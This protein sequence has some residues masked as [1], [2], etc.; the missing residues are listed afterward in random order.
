[1]S[2]SASL[3][4]PRH[5]FLLPGATA[6]AV[7]TVGPTMLAFN[8][9]PSSTFFNQAAAVA[10]WGLAL[11]FWSWRGSTPMPPTLPSSGLVALLV[12]LAVI[13]LSAAGSTIFGTLPSSIALSS[14][15]LVASAMLAAWM[16][17]WLAATGR[18]AAMFRALCIGLLIA[19]VLSAI[20]AAIQVFAPNWTT[21]EWI[22]SSGFEGRASGNLRQPNHLSSLLLWGLIA[23]VWAIESQ[24]LTWQLASPVAVLLVFGIVASSS[25]TG[26]VGVA[27]LVGWGVFDRKLLR[28]TRFLLAAIPVLYA[29]GW[30]AMAAWA[31]STHGVFLGEVRMTADGDIS[32]SRFAIWS[33]TLTL[34]K[35]HPWDGVGFGE[36]NFAWSLTPFPHRPV[37]FFDHTHNLL[38]QLA[39][40]LGIPLTI[41]VIGL[42]L[43]ALTRAFL[44]GFMSDG[45][46]SASLRCAFMIVLMIGLH[47]LLEYPLW[48]AYFLIPTAIAFGL[49][50]AKPPEQ[51]SRATIATGSN[52]V[53]TDSV[54]TVAAGLMFAL[55]VFSVFDYLRVADIFLSGS[56]IPL[57][58]RIEAGRHSIFFA[59]QADYAAATTTQPPMAAWTSFST[60]TH[61]LLD[62][63]LMI[64]WAQA[65]AERGDLDRAQHI[66]DRL[67][68]FRN[69]DAREFFAPCAFTVATKPFQCNTALKPMDYR[70]FLP[71]AGK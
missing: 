15:G 8:V 63:R 14:M 44:A 38:L 4:A 53:A 68:E 39:V 13:L 7:A 19:G 37:A 10:G 59:H 49:C 22:A 41:L 26:M 16:A 58:Q 62:T 67:R 70:D 30:F 42:L 35:K 40:E 71:A 66:A 21:G 69:E 12:A 65:Y 18:G 23:I 55:G 64:A 56:D 43:F 2:V 46:N 34:I 48:Y 61:N 36:F 1:M 3:V 50:L 25:R 33:D 29:L 32:S 45:E 52:S 17:Y 28:S 9:P 6:V 5:G 11:L 47:S 24:L 60:S 51:S 27:I 54:R 20:V 57:K 31:H